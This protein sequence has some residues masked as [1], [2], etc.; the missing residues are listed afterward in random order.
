MEVPMR[1]R[2]VSS[3]KTESRDIERAGVEAVAARADLTL[4]T[5]LR[6]HANLPVQRASLKLA[7]QAAQCI[8]AERAATKGAA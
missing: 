3:T 4:R 1:E 5:V 2:L 8:L 7:L 6:I